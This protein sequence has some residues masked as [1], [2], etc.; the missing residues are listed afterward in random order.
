VIK[1]GKASIVTD[2]IDTLT[3]TGIRLKSGIH[4][5]ADVIVTATGLVMEL[6]GGASLAVDGQTVRI[7]DTL[8]YKG[9][10]F[11]GVPNLTYSL[12]YTNASWTLKCDLTTA[13][14]CR[15]LNHMQKEG[16]SQCVPRNTD[17]SQVTE[18]VMPF[19]S[20]YV[21]RALSGLPKQGSHAPWKLN[22]NYA[23]DLMDL[24]FGSV[25]DNAMEF[26][27]LARHSRST[28]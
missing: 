4:L 13:Y 26:S 17:P 3:E 11:S 24:K 6:M 21:Q 28:I 18:P 16:F 2:H 7:A 25:A 22:Q 10:M 9:M 5:D 1:S 8:N 23:L 15:L 19:T 12:G 27:N 20:G 14:A